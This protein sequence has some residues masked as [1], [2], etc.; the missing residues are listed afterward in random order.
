[1]A[2]FLLT[3]L[4]VFVLGLWLSGWRF[5]WPVAYAFVGFAVLIMTAPATGQRD[6]KDNII[7]AAIVLVGTG[8]PFLIRQRLR[9]WTRFT[10]DRTPQS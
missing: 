6:L 3:A 10:R 5:A 7:L 4:A 9:L 1:M 8:I 2:T